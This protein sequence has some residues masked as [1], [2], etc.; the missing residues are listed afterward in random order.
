MRRAMGLLALTIG[1]G[2]APVRAGEAEVTPAPTPAGADY[3]RIEVRIRQVRRPTCWSVHLR[4][5]FY[6]PYAEAV[7][8]ARLVVRLRAA[9]DAAREMERLEETFEVEIEPNGSAPFA[10]EIH[11]ACTNA[12]FNDVSAIAFAV[13]RGEQAMPVMAASAEQQ[14][15]DAQDVAAPPVSV[16]IVHSQ[17]AI[18]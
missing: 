15:A 9:G 16:P 3:G 10:R 6:N 4:G 2:G 5:R 1:L 8:G 7:D 18:P 11:T 12:A 13:R 17:V 14:L